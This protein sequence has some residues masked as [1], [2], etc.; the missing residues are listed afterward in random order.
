MRGRKNSYA[1]LNSGKFKQFKQCQFES[2][3]RLV[4]WNLTGVIKKEECVKIIRFRGGSHIDYEP[5]LIRSG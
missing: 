1:S 3:L 2:I 4:N 5:M